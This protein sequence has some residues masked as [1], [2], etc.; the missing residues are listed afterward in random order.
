MSLLDSLNKKLFEKLGLSLE[1]EG[2]L[3]GLKKM[4]F[5]MLRICRKNK[6]PVEISDVLFFPK[7]ESLV[8]ISGKFQF[9]RL[10]MDH[11]LITNG[12]GSFY[13][14]KDTAT[15]NVEGY[16]QKQPVTM[17]IALDWGKSA[18]KEQDHVEL[19]FL[20]ESALLSPRKVFKSGSVLEFEAPFALD[21]KSQIPKNYFQIPNF[22]QLSWEG[23]LEAKSLVL[24]VVRFPSFILKTAKKENHAGVLRTESNDPQGLKTTLKLDYH[25]GYSL[26]GVLEFNQPL[27][28]LLLKKTVEFEGFGE[29]VHMN[30]QLNAESPS[31]S[32]LFKMI[33]MDG[34]FRVTPETPRLFDYH[35]FDGTFIL[36]GEQL[37]IQIP[38]IRM[39][40]GKLRLSYVNLWNGELK[41]G[42]YLNKVEV[43]PFSEMFD[44]S[45]ERKV[46][47][48]E[49][50]G[51]IQNPVSQMFERSLGLKGLATGK[52][53]SV[54]NPGKN[55]A[56]AVIDLRIDDGEFF[57]ATEWF[58]RVAPWKEFREFRKQFVSLGGF[59]HLI[60]QIQKSGHEYHIGQL[61]LLG[62][63][64]QNLSL[65]GSIKEGGKLDMVFDASFFQDMP[66]WIVT[67]KGP[68]KAPL[69]LPAPG[70][71]AEK[72]FRSSQKAF[73]GVFDTLK[74]LTK[75]ED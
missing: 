11:F 30:L 8:R 42:F 47:A 66:S 22:N 29:A 43:A 72:L 26:D 48:S 27:L 14:H 9:T 40:E 52:V 17:N 28:S 68:F 61:K 33:H 50:M 31:M 21:L 57:K 53:E 10:Q 41:Y 13:L 35:I 60:V 45:R 71:M 38:E 49:T 59:H 36:D 39:K 54:Q 75:S 5:G 2:F 44:Q 73:K 70:K 4:R 69:I 62:H 16:W 67:I 37:N 46:T 58:Q 15:V 7:L 51:I 3:F 25:S 63:L 18:S 74:D 32:Q 1:I 19:H 55:I 20:F 64:Q 12:E 23:S 65:S 34:H 56:D 24:D 6:L